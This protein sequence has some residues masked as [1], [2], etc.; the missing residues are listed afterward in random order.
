M[1]AGSKPSV[2]KTWDLASA[3]LKTRIRLAS[4][5]TLTVDQRARFAAAVIIPKSLFI[6]RHSWPTTA[7]TKVL[8]KCIKNYVWAGRF[9]E[10]PSSPTPWLAEDI[11]KLPRSEGG[12]AFPDLKAELLAMAATTVT[13]WA[14]SGSVIEHLVGD[15]LH[16][17]PKSGTAPVLYV[18]PHT[19]GSL[20]S[21]LHAGRTMWSTGVYM[22][23]SAGAAQPPEGHE[24]VVHELYAVVH[25]AL[26]TPLR[27]T[28]NEC[29]LNLMGLLGGETAGQ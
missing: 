23:H 5:K 16:H 19:R 25:E 1:Q 21:G 18:T 12:M 10:Q 24:R 3:Q 20:T 17:G 26:Q 22:I 28:H 2:T 8:A 15:I 13:E 9:D 29:S 27:W 14:E 6:G 4:Q 11:T 7:I